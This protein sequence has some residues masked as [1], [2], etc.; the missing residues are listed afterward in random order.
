VYLPN[1]LREK[2]DELSPIK[3]QTGEDI[4][5]HVVRYWMTLAAME[6]MPSPSLYTIG[7]W[8]RAFLLTESAKSNGT[9]KSSVDNLPQKVMRGCGTTEISEQLNS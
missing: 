9:M 3:N 1:Y 7:V 5:P 6:K 4:P 2:L 8:E